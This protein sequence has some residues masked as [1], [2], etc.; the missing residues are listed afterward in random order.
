MIILRRKIITIRLATKTQIATT[1]FILL[2]STGVI[3]ADMEKEVAPSAPQVQQAF[4][5]L[6]KDGNGKLTQEE[7]KTSPELANEFAKID[8]DNNGDIDVSEY[9]QF[10]SPAT[11]AGTPEEAPTQAMK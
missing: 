9:V 6:D 3:A 7:L 2:F 1:A 8:A 11:A 4:S 10:T 5:V